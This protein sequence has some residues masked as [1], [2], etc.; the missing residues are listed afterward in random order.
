[1]SIEEL[2]TAALKLTP[3]ERELLAVRLLSSVESRLD[4]EAE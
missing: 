1:M 3:A 2:E 4:S